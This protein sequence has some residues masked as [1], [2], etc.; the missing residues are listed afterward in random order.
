M[1][2][3][4]FDAASGFW[5]AGVTFTNGGALCLASDARPRKFRYAVSLRSCRW[6]LCMRACVRVLAARVGEESG[7]GHGVLHTL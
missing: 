1:L 3:V 7:W 2:P 6:S 5:D 4:D